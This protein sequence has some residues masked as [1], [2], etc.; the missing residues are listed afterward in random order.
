M[1]VSDDMLI[2]NPEYLDVL[3]EVKARIAAARYRSMAAVNSELVMLYWDVGT[4]I[5][6]HKEWGNKFITNLSRDV[7][8]AN[9][10][11]RGFSARNLTYMATFAASYPDREFAQS[12]TAQI[13][14]TQNVLLLDKAH[15]PVQR[16]WYTEQTVEQG[17][18]VRQLESAIEH[19]FYERQE[20][21]NKVTNFDTKLEAPQREL[22][23]DILKDPYIFDFIDYR[24]GMVE[25]EIEDEL[26]RNI[27]QLLIELG[28]GFA[29]VGQQ[30]RIEVEGE[31]FY[32]DLLFYHLKLRCYIV[33]ELKTT[34]FKPGYAGQ[35]NFYV[36]AINNLIATQDDNPTIGILL[37]KSKKGMV[38]EYAFSGMT[39][40]MGVSEYQLLDTLPIEYEDLIPSAADIESRLR[41]SICDSGDTSGE[42]TESVWV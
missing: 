10:H 2:N 42:H 23:Q 1:K 22:A 13:S 5:N 3:N 20:L 16:R 15:S 12:V 19:Q 40:P 18:S 7:R 28:A 27:A 41:L 17:W 11:L 21:S 14:W 32:I 24:E 6:D 38:A 26:V 9:P 30:Y 31:D 34:D 33:V 35:L 29:F 36:A 25:R 39:Q 4:L 37:V 8:G